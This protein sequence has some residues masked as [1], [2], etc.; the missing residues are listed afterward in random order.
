MLGWIRDGALYSSAG[1]SAEAKLTRLELYP[2]VAIL[3]MEAEHHLL[4]TAHF[5]DGHTEDYTHQ[6]L[7][8]VNDGEV[9]SVDAGGGVIAKRR[10]ESAILVRAEGQVASLGVGVIGPRLAEYPTVA[11][12]NF[13]DDYVFEKL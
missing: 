4:V 8:S 5:D 9:A 12:D 10:G 7:Y 11:R 2:S 3:P 6:A 13:I 1:A